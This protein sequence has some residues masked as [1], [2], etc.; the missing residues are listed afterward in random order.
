MDDVVK[1]NA[2]SGKYRIEALAV[3]CGTDWSVSVCGGEFHHVGAVALAQYEPERGSATASCITVYAHRDDMVAVRFAKEISKVLKASVSVTAGIH[4]DNASSQE[5]ALLNE[6]SD[7]CL[8]SL[9]EKA[10]EL[11]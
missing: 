2:G 10:E 6:N 11:K 9:L 4:V 1:A 8:R 3:R 5:I 7:A